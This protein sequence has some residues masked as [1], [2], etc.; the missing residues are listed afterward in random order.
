MKEEKDYDEYS[1][2]IRAPLQEAYRLASSR[3]KIACASQKKGYDKR[4][5]SVAPEVGDLVLVNKLGFKGKHKIQDKFK[6]KVYIIIVK[7]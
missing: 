4:M 3:S 7:D 1:D 2:N 6:Q 5:H